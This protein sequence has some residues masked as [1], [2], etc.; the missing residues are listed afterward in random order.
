MSLFTLIKMDFDRYCT[1]LEIENYQSFKKYI[2]LLIRST[3][4]VLLLFRLAGSKV[5]LIRWASLPFYKLGRIFSGIQIPRGTQIG[6]GLLLPHYGNIVINKR[7]IV[8]E[9][10]TILHNVTLAAKGGGGDDGVPVVGDSVYIGAG[11]ILLGS[12][13][14][15][16]DVIIGASA[17]VTKDI[18]PNHISYGN[19]AKA[20]G[21]LS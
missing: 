2:Y 19:P 14:V 12:I 18:P 7:A 13:N 10:C 1:H 21:R 6:G 11:A 3:F 4:L 9:N 8:G 5:A 20:F 17:V 16:S 15:G